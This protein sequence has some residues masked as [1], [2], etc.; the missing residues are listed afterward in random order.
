MVDKLK[1]PLAWGRLRLAV[2]AGAI[3]AVIALCAFLSFRFGYHSEVI[4]E[5]WLSPFIFIL[6]ICVGTEAGIALMP[7]YA[8]FALSL[9]V[10]AAYIATF[11]LPDFVLV[12]CILSFAYVARI[13]LSIDSPLSWIMAVGTALVFHYVPT[14]FRVWGHPLATLEP[15]GHMLIA[16]SQVGAAL[17]A[18]GLKRYLVSLATLRRELSLQAQFAEN[19]LAA[20][21]GYQQHLEMVEL[22]SRDE[23]RNRITMEIHN[24]LGYNLTNISMMMEAAANV[25]NPGEGKVRDLIAKTRE[26]AIEGLYEMRKSLRLLR[27]RE[28]QIDKGIS[29]F[30]KLIRA[31]GDSTGMDVEVDY[32]NLEWQM[33]DRLERAV[34]RILQEAMTNALRHGRATKIR[35][36]FWEEKNKVTLTIRDNGIESLGPPS[37]G[38]GLSGIREIAE[39]FNGSIQTSSGIDGFKLEVVLAIDRPTMENP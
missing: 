36:S 27:A 5:R 23:E 8:S 21:L 2:Q 34:Y 11:P 7:R 26:Q 28:I 17:L 13:L 35:I 3:A 19:L 4:Q 9:E 12:K 24:S 14:D 25:V 6:A 39:S 15:I 32:R 37:A 30:Q 22:H 1:A 20:N 29:A 33:D 10:V 16:S 31:F 18:L 38:I